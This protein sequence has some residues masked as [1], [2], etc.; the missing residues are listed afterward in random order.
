MSSINKTLSTII[1][2]GSLVAAGAILWSSPAKKTEAAIAVVEDGPRPGPE[3]AA[4]AAR[5]EQE[6][7]AA[8]DANGGEVVEVTPP[9]PTLAIA[10]ED[11]AANYEELAKD[12]LA[13]G[14]V[15]GAF[16][17]LRKHIYDHPPTVEILLNIGRT[18]RQAGELAI[19]EQ[20]LL[21]AAKLDPRSADIELELARVLLDNDELSDA[22]IHVRQAIRFDPENALA[23][24]VAGRIAMQESHWQRAETALRRALEIDPT[25]AMFHNNMGL[26]YIY[27]NK[28]DEAVDSLE[29]AVELFGDDTPYFVYNNLGLAHEMAKNY[30]EARDAFEEALVGN[31]DYARARVNL[32][33]V[34][35]TLASSA[36]K[37]VFETAKGVDPKQAADAQDGTGSL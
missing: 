1:L 27:M 9:K 18:G 35:G 6:T 12:A 37:K 32:N 23:W 4:P 21:D 25:N 26:L 34:L 30:D 13:D 7:V 33:R 20:A 31:P 2:G 24:N 14:D 8:V 19:A 16:I 11:S 17:A 5:P 28:A 36:E 10:P 22:R 3:K 15:K 29:T